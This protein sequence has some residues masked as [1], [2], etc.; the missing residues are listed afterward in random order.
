LENYEEVAVRVLLDSGTTGLFMDTKFAKRRGFKLKR[1]RNPLL[2]RNID[3]TINIGKAIMHQVE[4]NMFFKKY[5]KRVKIDIYNLGKTEVILGILWLAVYN[6][7]I[8]WEKGKVKMMRC[9]LIYGRKKRR[10][11]L[12]KWKRRKQ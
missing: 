7:E 3:E 6:L 12:G 8:D 4:C 2:V 11:R 9:L 1:L 10:K 5:V